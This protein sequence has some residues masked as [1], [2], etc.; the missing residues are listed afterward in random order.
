[1]I[2]RGRTSLGGQTLEDVIRAIRL[3]GFVECDFK[4]L[5]RSNDDMFDNDERLIVKNTPYTTVFGTRGRREYFLQ[6][7][8]WTGE[9]ECKFQG[10]GGSTDEKMVY[11][12]ETLRR[13]ALER[14]VIV[15]GGPYWIKKERGKAIIRWLK[16]EAKSM[17]HVHGKELLVFTLDEF[18]NWVQRTWGQ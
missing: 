8:E 3:A 2:G 7:P 11:V 5:T 13:T 17:K 9:L 6:S 15:Y 4:E 18:L 10:G 16:Q 14:L 12:T 1:M